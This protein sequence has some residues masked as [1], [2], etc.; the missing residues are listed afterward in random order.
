MSANDPNVYDT[1]MFSICPMCLK[2][3]ICVYGAERPEFQP[4]FF[5]SPSAS[6]R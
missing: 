2:T 6:A 3:K 1:P 5:G 4:H